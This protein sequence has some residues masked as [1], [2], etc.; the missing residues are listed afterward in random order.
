[1]NIL[2]WVLFLRK[3]Q[4]N[5]RIPEFY[6]Q[7]WEWKQSQD[8]DNH[9]SGVWDWN[10]AQN[11]ILSLR[12]V[13]NHHPLTYMHS[14]STVQTVASL[15]NRPICNRLIPTMANHDITDIKLIFHQIR[16]WRGKH[17]YKNVVYTIKHSAS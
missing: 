11:S 14:H 7:A 2:S 3:V 17:V 10:W 15:V 8:F 16:S 9:H 5:R 12:F 4:T 13:S 1:M 6:A